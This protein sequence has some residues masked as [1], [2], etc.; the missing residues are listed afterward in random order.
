ML[1]GKRIPNSGQYSSK[2]HEVNGEMHEKNSD[3]G[4]THPLLATAK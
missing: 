2:N 4:F 1:V 3:F